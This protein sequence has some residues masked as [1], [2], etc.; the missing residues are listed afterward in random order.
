MLVNIKFVS[1]KA[2]A[3]YSTDPVFTTQEKSGF[4][5]NFYIMYHATDSANVE[6]IL[7]GG[8]NLSTGPKQ[9]LGDGI[10]CSLTI[11]KVW[12]EI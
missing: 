6:S 3:S 4:H 7:Q 10:Y 2:M 5:H 8:F 1:V 9:M 12:V 11:D